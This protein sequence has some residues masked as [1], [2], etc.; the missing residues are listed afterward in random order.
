MMVSIIV[1]VYNTGK[2]LRECIESVLQQSY[3]DWELLLMDDGS[4]DDS[5]KICDEYASFDSRIKVVHK[6]NTGVSDTRNIALD[7][8]VGK[9]IIFLDSDDYWAN[10]LFLGEFVTFSETNS[11]DVLRGEYVEVNITNQ[12]LGQSKVI[13]YRNNYNKCVVDNVTF[14]KDI[15]C[16]EY[17]SVLCLFRKSY[18]EN[19]R[20]NKDRVFLEDAEFYVSLLKKR[21]R[22]SYIKNQ[23]YSYRKHS[24]A[25]SVKHV[26]QK[27]KDAFD[28]SR[29]CFHQADIY[30]EQ[31][32]YQRF[33]VEEGIKNY[34]FDISVISNKAWQRNMINEFNS[35]YALDELRRLAINKLVEFRLYKYAIVLLPLVVLYRYYYIRH[36]LRI[37]LKG[38]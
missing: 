17:F 16:S 31:Y 5:G 4:T 14:L 24:D 32:D 7:L 22:F 34:L 12:I 38:A 36:T 30:E 18:I 33:C 27:M 8:A 23:F 9:Y 21:G 15:I 20:F 6:N 10:T 28:F 2:Y 19:L 1:P 26:P 37:L 13:L 3:Q 29:F 11:L 35:I 25:V